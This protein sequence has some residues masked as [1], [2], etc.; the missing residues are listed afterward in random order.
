[1]TQ[2]I[3]NIEKGLEDNKEEM[4][5]TKESITT[6]CAGVE[7][8]QITVPNLEKRIATVKDTNATI[9][10]MLQN[11]KKRAEQDKEDIQ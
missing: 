7:N 2:R 9:I 6:V 8:L 10:Q 1:M 4:V 11:A 3:D 5:Q